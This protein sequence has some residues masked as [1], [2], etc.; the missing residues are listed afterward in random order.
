MISAVIPTLNE[1]AEIAAT[2]QAL[3][4]QADDL[5][6]IVADG[7]SSD[8]T[9]EIAARLGAVIV[10]S[11]R[12]RGTQMHAGALAARGDTLWFVHADTRVCTDATR[13]LMAALGTPRTMGGN[14]T[15]A[16][17]GQTLGARL[18]TLSQPLMKA[19]QVYYGDSTIFLRREVY[20]ALGGFRPYPLFED[21]DLI[22]RMRAAGAFR[23]L[24]GQVTTSSRR[25]ES[26][27]FLLSCTQWST[28]QLL[29]WLGVPAETLGRFY[30]PIRR[31]IAPESR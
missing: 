7:G 21:A 3:L 5:E 29:Y 10:R 11:A 6:V 22:G 16:F 13:Q 19:L 20:F 1:E 30:A 2:I 24:T 8:A 31:K 27:G 23:S 18:L 28:M 4:A 9:V 26:R 14:F 17:D 15:L 25:L 12:G